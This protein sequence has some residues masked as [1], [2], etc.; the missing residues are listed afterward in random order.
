MTTKGIHF[1]KES[2][3]SKKIRPGRYD[4]KGIPSMKQLINTFSSHPGDIIKVT[5]LEGWNID[6]I[7]DEL[8]K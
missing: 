4:L 8:Y 2:M 1:L 6:Q 5:I 3:N 7:S